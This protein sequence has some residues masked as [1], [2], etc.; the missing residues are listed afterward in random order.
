VV[1]NQAGV[2]NMKK[3]ILTLF[4]SIGIIGVTNADYQDG[5]NAYQ[6]GDYEE[7]IQEWIPLA[8][9]GNDNALAGLNLIITNGKTFKRYL[10]DSFI[11]LKDEYKAAEQSSD[12]H[13]QNKLAY[14]IALRHKNGWGTKVKIANALYWINKTST[15]YKD[16]NRVKQE[17]KIEREREKEK[18]NQESEIIWAN[19]AGSMAPSDEE[20]RE[21]EEYLQNLAE[22]R[23]ERNQN[24]NKAFTISIIGMLFGDSPSTSLNTG[25]GAVYEDSSYDGPCPCPYSLD[26]K[27]NSCGARSA[28]SRS[29]G[30]SPA[31]FVP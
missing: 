22:K 21:A 27:G 16:S 30:E 28:W 23:S 1:K 25:F 8:A 17:L 26:I 9:E 6:K 11:K 7:A 5:L 15:G 24:F 13:R 4:L 19:W 10:R 18:K 2:V 31:C 20:L 12:F 14:D 29:G 3:I